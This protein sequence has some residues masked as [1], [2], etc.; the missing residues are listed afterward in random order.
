MGRILCFDFG[1]KRIGIAVTD[2]LKII[3]SPLTTCKSH[4]IFTFIDNYLQENNVDKFLVGMPINLKGEPTNSTKPT[5]HFIKK[6]ESK[7]PEVNVDTYDERY[8][9][10]I[11]KDSLI[12]MG[13]NKKYRRKKSNIDKLS[14]SIILQSYLTRRK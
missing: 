7:Y 9:S 5:I 13:K 4:E 12:L 10:K 11:A 1:L 14:A 6:L 8:T 3:S 2:E